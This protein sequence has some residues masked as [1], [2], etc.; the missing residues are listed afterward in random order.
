MRRPDLATTLPWSVIVS[1]G[2]GEPEGQPAAEYRL[3][4]LVA[5]TYL[6]AALIPVRKLVANEVWKRIDG[7]VSDFIEVSTRDALIV[8]MSGAAVVAVEEIQRHASGTSM[9]KGS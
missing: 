1:S 9:P 3:A 5:D 8:N 6:E 2:P 4:G 7:T